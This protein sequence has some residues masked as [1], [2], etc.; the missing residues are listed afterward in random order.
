ML[1][2]T[3]DQVQLQAYTEWVHIFFGYILIR[4]YWIPVYSFHFLYK[5]EKWGVLF[6]LF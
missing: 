2:Y 1:K 4:V 3:K 6:I 5:D